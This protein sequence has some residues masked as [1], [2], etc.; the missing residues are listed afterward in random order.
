MDCPLLRG[1]R[2]PR[3]LSWKSCCRSGGGSPRGLGACPTDPAIRIQES[4]A[5]KKTKNL[6]LLEFGTQGA[7]LFCVQRRHKSGRRAG[8]SR[9]KNVQE[10]EVNFTPTRETEISRFGCDASMRKRTAEG[11]EE[12][13]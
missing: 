12:N 6:P 4:I 3:S 5:H 7:F 10:Q 8:R 13:L 11:R 1:L 9:R 2:P